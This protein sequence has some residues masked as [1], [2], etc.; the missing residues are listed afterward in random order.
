MTDVDLSRTRTA[1]HAVAELL[2]AGPQY[3]ASG[4]IKLRVAPSG[5]RTVA[6]PEVAVVGTD[7]VAN[8]IAVPIS[9][10]SARELARSVNVV[11]GAALG[12]Y[13]DGSG[14][15]LDDELLIDDA[16]AAQLADVYSCGDAALRLLAPDVEPV[17]WPEH[18]DVGIRL[19]AVNYGISPGDDYLPE[20]YAYVGVDAVP[21]GDPYW[22]APFGRVE[23][24]TEFVEPATLRDFFAEARTRAG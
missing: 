22:N 1:L 19:D 2:L 15:G 3:R 7:L 17:L 9:G 18:F 5:F 23:P 21:V 16:A 14:V 8:G 24:M 6:E 20:P 11:A 13:Q 4:T 10:N 12:V